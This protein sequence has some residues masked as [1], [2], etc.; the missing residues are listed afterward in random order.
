MELAEASPAELGASPAELV[1]LGA[2]LWAQAAFVARAARQAVSSG[3]AA[4]AATQ[5]AGAAGQ[6][7][8]AAQQAVIALAARQ[9]HGTETEA[10][11]AESYADVV[12]TFTTEM[13]TVPVVMLQNMTD[14]DTSLVLYD[15]DETGFTARVYNNSQTDEDITFA[16]LAQS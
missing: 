3:V 15:V 14:I 10:V 11:E 16:W 1:A 7:A 9:L 6:T 2:A 12:I 4:Q 8:N 13:Q 5:A